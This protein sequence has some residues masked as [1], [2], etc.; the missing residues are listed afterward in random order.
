M[1][2]K[3]LGPGCPKCKLTVK[4]IGEVV[5]RRGLH[6]TI[7]HVHDVES[8]ATYGAML[9]PAVIVDGKLVYEGHVPT[10]EEVEKFLKK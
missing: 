1:D 4:M 3:V 10:E 5:K 9:T 8:F 2:I 6:A 7:E